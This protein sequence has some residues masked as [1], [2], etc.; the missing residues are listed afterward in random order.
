[1][2]RALPEIRSGLGW[3]RAVLAVI[4]FLTGILAAQN[5]PALDRARQALEKGD[6]KQAIAWLE[7]YRR[8]HPT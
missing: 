5:D 4:L 1:M 6:T 7:D 8:A 3:G 2:N